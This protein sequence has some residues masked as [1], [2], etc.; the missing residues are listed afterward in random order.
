LLLLPVKLLTLP[1][2]L[3]LLLLLLLLI[4]LVVVVV[5][6]LP[7]LWMPVRNPVAPSPTASL[8]P[9]THSIVS[10]RPRL[11]CGTSRGTRT[12]GHATLNA[13]IPPRRAS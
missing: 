11:S 10:T 4:V 3:L 7:T 13:P 6:L 2:P 1:L 12:P 9:A 5:A 8:S